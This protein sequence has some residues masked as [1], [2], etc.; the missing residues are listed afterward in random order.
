MGE[1]EGASNTRFLKP[2]QQIAWTHLGAGVGNQ[3]GNVRSL[4]LQS[5]IALATAAT[6]VAALV[7]V[8]VIVKVMGPAEDPSMPQSYRHHSHTR[9]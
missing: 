7:K 9:H 3:C 2:T 8:D 4:A 5:L 1:H 6:T